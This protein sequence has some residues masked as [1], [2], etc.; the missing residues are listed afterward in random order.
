[1]TISYIGH[2][3]AMGYEPENTMR[4]F[5]RAVADGVDAIELDLRLSKDGAIVIMHDADVDRTTNGAGPVAE[6]TLG[7]IQALDAGKGERVPTFEEVLAGV[8]IAIEAELKCADAVD[9]LLDLIGS[10]P[11]L[12]RRVTPTSFHDEFIDR[13]TRRFPDL[14]CGLISVPG[15]DVLDRAAAVRAARVMLNWRGLT[16]ELVAEARARGFAFNVWPSNTLEELDRAVAIGADGT[17]TNYPSLIAEHR[18]R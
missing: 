13:V 11:E 8:D 15:P 6:L 2:R 7:E 3:G 18:R 1:M 9:P 12:A 16:G 10:D 14:P 4:S 5:R 17:T